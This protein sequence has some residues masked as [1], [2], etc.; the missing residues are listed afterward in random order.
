L[1]I[2]VAEKL[3]PDLTTIL[4]QLAATGV[5]LLFFRKFLWGPMQEYFAKRSQMIETNIKDAKEMQE[6]AK[7]FVEESELQSRQAAI[8]YCDILEQAKQDAMHT[9]ETMLA[10]VQKEAKEKRKQAEIEIEAQK[11]I[12]KR[13]MKEEIIQVALD[14]ASKIM[15]KEMDKETNEALIKS[16]IAEVEENGSDS[17]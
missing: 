10:D 3:F 11:E 13:E 9:K 7:V 12:A 8:E 15:D 2:N 4:V 17:E 6:K 1:D 16:F 5:M 14:A